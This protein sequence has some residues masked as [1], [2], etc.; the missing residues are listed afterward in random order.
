MLW[1]CICKNLTVKVFE[2]FVWEEKGRIVK[3]L[4]EVK[5]FKHLN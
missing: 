3:L 5:L 2:L 1:N 4:V